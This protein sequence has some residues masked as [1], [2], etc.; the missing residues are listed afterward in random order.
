MSI[1]MSINFTHRFP[2]SND[3]ASFMLAALREIRSGGKKG[4][5]DEDGEGE[6]D[7]KPI[8]GPLMGPAIKSDLSVVQAP[9]NFS[10]PGVLE[11]IGLETDLPVGFLRLRWAMLHKESS[12]LKEAFWADVMQY[13][14]I[15][16]QQWSSNEN[17]IGL[18]S[19]PDGVDE[20]SFLNVSTLCP[21]E[22]TTGETFTI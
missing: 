20:N 21:Y 15:E 10:P 5:V 1:L 13:E 7:A 22:R 17:D 6:E 14:K 4:Q 11:F 9:P 8:I 12:F 2:Y 16:M 19:L 18:P 3:Q